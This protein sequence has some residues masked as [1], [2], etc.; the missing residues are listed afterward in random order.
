MFRVCVVLLIY[1]LERQH[2]G[3]EFVKHDEEI[4]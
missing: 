1:T 4:D 3:G 2:Y